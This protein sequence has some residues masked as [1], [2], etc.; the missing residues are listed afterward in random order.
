MCVAVG[1]SHRTPHLH[2]FKTAEHPE[3]PLVMQARQWEALLQAK[4]PITV[5]DWKF[6]DHAFDGETELELSVDEKGVH[7][8]RITH[9]CDENGSRLRISEKQAL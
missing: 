7:A 1:I 6:G 3:R 9:A 4:G 8:T 5:I 2:V